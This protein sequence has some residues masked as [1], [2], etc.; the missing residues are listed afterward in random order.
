VSNID[1]RKYDRKG[2]SIVLLRCA[3]NLVLAKR[4]HAGTWTQYD[5]CKTYD[6]ATAPLRG[7]RELYGI[8]AQAATEP[9]ICAVRGSLVAGSKVTEIRRRSV[10]DPTTGDPPTLRDI[11]R[12]WLALDLDK[13]PIPDDVDRHDLVAC[14]EAVMP[15]LPPALQSAQCIVQA[16][17]S[18]TF[19]PGVNLRLW[20]WLYRPLTGAELKRWLSRD[21]RGRIDDSV[22]IPSQVIYIASPIFVDGV[23]PLPSRLARRHGEPWV[24]TPSPD[25]LKPPDP[26]AVKCGGYSKLDTK[27][28]AGIIR[29]VLTAENGERNR[30]L[31]WSS[32]R[33]GEA[34]R[35]G[36]IT[37]LDAMNILIECARRID[38]DETEILPTIRSGIARGKAGDNF[39]AFT[40]ESE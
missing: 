26:A 17:A 30:R 32:A 4:C 27:R 21:W 12:Y 1:N 19:K 29:N 8:L 23:D 34:I 6:G 31:H 33:I 36:D 40:F 24:I 3:P 10:P 39:S 9:R 20:F 5:R 28:L 35:H 22:F 15:R 11:A 2:D 38:M 18:H 25:E 13:Q 37:E 7:L 16:T 14:A